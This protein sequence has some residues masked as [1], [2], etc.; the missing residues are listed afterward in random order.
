MFEIISNGRVV[1]LFREVVG[2]CHL[3]FE[4]END[5]EDSIIS[6]KEIS[7]TKHPATQH[8]ST[9]N[10][11]SRLLSLVR[12]V[13]YIYISHSY[14]L[15]STSLLCKS[16]FF[17]NFK[18]RILFYYS[19]ITSIFF[20][21]RIEQQFHIVLHDI[22]RE[23]ADDPKPDWQLYCVCVRCIKIMASGN[24]PKL[25]ILDTGIV[26]H[27]VRI[28]NGNPS[29]VEVIWRSLNLLTSLSYV[30][31]DHRERFFSKQLFEIVSNQMKQLKN[32]KVFGYGCFFFISMSENDIGARY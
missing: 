19:L 17:Y 23:I 2:D 32:G 26:S 1:F 12:I 7:A 15:I 30:A 11:F 9:K 8:S 18:Y 14:V 22:F 25:A 21:S 10:R 20:F 28:L 4:W 6:F 5:N 13:F 16:D 31:K 24:V 27:I 3:L 29:L